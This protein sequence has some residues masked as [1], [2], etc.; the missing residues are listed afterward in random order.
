MPTPEERLELAADLAE[1]ASAI[2]SDFANGPS[3]RNVTPEPI[4]GPLPTLAEFLRQK[5][6]EI[7]DNANLIAGF[8]D[9]LAATDSAVLVGGV[10]AGTIQVKLSSISDLNH[11]TKSVSRD[12]AVDSYHKGYN[13]GGGVFSWYDGVDKSLHDGGNIIDPDKIFPVDWDNDSI[14]IWLAP[15]NSGPGCFVRKERSNSP[16]HYG[17]KNDYDNRLPLQAVIN[18][19]SANGG[20]A[21]V[22]PAVSFSVSSSPI[23]GIAIDLKDK[24]YVSL[25]GATVNLLPNDFFSYSIFS[26]GLNITGGIFGGTLVGDRYSHLSATGEFGFGIIA[27]G[28]KSLI[29]RDLVAKD[30]WGDGIYIGSTLGSGEAEPCELVLLDNVICDG[31]RRQGLSIVA[32]NHLIIPYGEFKNT[33]GT[34]P[35][36]GIDIEPNTNGRVGLVEIGTVVL[37]NN[38]GQGMLVVAPN[39]PASIENIHIGK[40][41]ARNN[42]GS[43]CSLESYT[44]FSCNEI[45]T[46][47]NTLESVSFSSTVAESTVCDS[48]IS[49]ND[50][51]RETIRTATVNARSAGSTQISSIKVSDSTAVGSSV[52]VS[53]D[54]TTIS[55]IITTDSG[56]LGNFD[57]AINPSS[58][59]AV[60]GSVT[61]HNVPKGGV[62][63]AA[64]GGGKVNI[65]DIIATKLLG[66]VLQNAVQINS[67][68][69]QVSDIYIH[70]DGV[71]D[72]G[73]R[74]SG[75]KSHVKS[76]ISKLSSV[77]FPVNNT[78]T[79]T[80]IG[81]QETF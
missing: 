63:V 54:L 7:D 42:G 30:C 35:A 10:E 6:I 22:V 38:Q 66:S 14:E 52:Q 81:F 65:G 46:S 17:F 75:N 45:I 3:G 56:A 49:S 5:E 32:V 25:Y 78:S 33:S 43:G 21:V 19:V 27:R 62:L 13:F 26:A 44:N 64:G 67:P 16:Y 71:F 55:S 76:I 37:D 41:I 2:A 77:T 8:A 39:L 40:I 69:T 68:Y 24:V 60:I 15:T 28:V 12:Y 48:I 59:V 61:C 1:N 47:G 36:S 31:N 79:G 73:L 58:G 50:G 9:A 80:A 74:I 23:T 57:V 20:G 53:S 11:T 18:S 34:L 70:G 29:V 72:N 51:S 4:A